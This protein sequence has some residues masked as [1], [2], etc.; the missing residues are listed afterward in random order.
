MK[1]EGELFAYD[2]TKLT[3]SCGYSLLKEQKTEYKREL[4][5]GSD[6]KPQEKRESNGVASIRRR[7]LLIYVHIVC[8]SLACV[9]RKKCVRIHFARYE[10]KLFE[11]Y[12]LRHCLEILFIRTE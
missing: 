10:R 2:E 7:R 8:L 11:D 6:I 3:A 1:R 9:T 4:F 5:T 12:A